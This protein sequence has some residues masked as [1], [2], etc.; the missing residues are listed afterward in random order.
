MESNHLTDDR[1]LR[2][3]YGVA[4]G[5]EDEHLA[6]CRQCAEAVARLADS[7]RARS[8]RAR[9]D[10]G[11]TVR[12][13][14]SGPHEPNQPNL[15][16]ALPYGRAS[17]GASTLDSLPEAFWQ[18][19]RAA[20]LEAIARPARRPVLRLAFVL[21]TVLLALV[22][23][24]VSLLVSRPQRPLIRAEDEQLFRQVC[25]TA[26]RIEPEALA[27]ARLLLPDDPAMKVAAPGQ[28]GSATFTAS[29]GEGGVVFSMVVTAEQS[30]KEQTRRKR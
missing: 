20:V 17:E 2:A 4:S 27:P 10:R 1:L 19:Q 7:V 9:F 11:A 24:G 29:A 21:A 6:G 15:G 5:E 28:P 22:A 14:V 30:V 18:R 13:R 25:E 8:D 26:N 16:D 12:E 3:A 23:V